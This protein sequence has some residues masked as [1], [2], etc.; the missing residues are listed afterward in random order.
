MTLTG[1]IHYNQIHPTHTW[2]ISMKRIS[3]ANFEITDLSLDFTIYS[4]SIVLGET[5]DPEHPPQTIDQNTL[6]L[7][8][9]IIIDGLQ[10]YLK[11][12]LNNLHQTDDST[13]PASVQNSVKMGIKAV[14]DSR[15]FDELRAIVTDL[16]NNEKSHIY[17]INLF[18]TSALQA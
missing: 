7:C 11:D 12:C 14:L 5:V 3:I 13:L 1:T 16:D 17:L 9:K 18:L 10:A 4:N 8:K 2:I 6:N 15:S